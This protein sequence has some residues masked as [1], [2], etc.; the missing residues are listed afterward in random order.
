M[1]VTTRVIGIFSRNSPFFVPKMTVCD[2][3]KDRGSGRWLVSLCFLLVT[4]PCLFPFMLTFI[5]VLYSPISPLQ[6][7]DHETSIQVF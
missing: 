1:I 7:N 4:D 2:V 6:Y 5:H 3:T